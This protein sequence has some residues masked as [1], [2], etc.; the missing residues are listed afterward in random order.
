MIPFHMESTPHGF[1]Y[2]CVQMVPCLIHQGMA[3]DLTF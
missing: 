2:A 1:G 3:E